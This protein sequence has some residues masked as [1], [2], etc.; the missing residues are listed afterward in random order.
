[1][2]DWESETVVPFN[3]SNGISLVCVSWLSVHVSD[4]APTIKKSATIAVFACSPCRTSSSDCVGA[5]LALPKM[6]IKAVRFQL[7]L[8]N[9]RT[10]LFARCNVCA[11]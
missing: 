7:C 3:W 5:C 6:G 11:A 9:H 10:D 2:G 4:M 8:G 1:M